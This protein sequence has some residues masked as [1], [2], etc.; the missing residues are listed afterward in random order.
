MTRSGGDALTGA[1]L[2][3]ADPALP[4]QAATKAYVDAQSAASLPKAG[5]ILSGPLTLSGDPTT[6]MQAVT[7]QY[8]DTRIFRSGDTLTGALILSSDPVISLQA[9][10]K[11]YV[12]TQFGMT[13]PKTGGSI[14]G[15]LLLNAD[16]TATNQAATKHY[17]DAQLTGVLPLSG[18]SLTGPLTL[19]SAP[20]AAA[21]AATKQYV[22]GQMSTALPL[23]GGTLTGALTLAVA[24]ATPMAAATKQYVDAAAIGTGTI[25]VKSAPYNAQLNGVTDDTAAFKAA[26][27]AAQAG[28]VIYVP[29]GV[30]V[31]QNP[32][33]WG[34]SLTKRVKWIVDGTTLVDGTPLASAIPSGTNPV[35][36][37][38]PGV[39]VGNTTL[40]AEASQ[41]GSQATDLA[42]LHSSYI[43]DHAGGSSGS[44]S[45][46]TRTDTLIYNSPNNYIWGGVDRLVW[47]GIQTPTAATP[48]QHVGRYVQT[49]RQTIGTNS[50]GAP[51]PQPQLWAACLEMRDAT[52]KPSSWSNASLTVEMDFI[53]NGLDDANNRQIQSLVVQQHDTSGAPVEV[54]TII[55]VYLAVG[56][57]GHAKT[58]FGVG[59]PFSRAVLDTTYATQLTGA[60]AIRLAAG[61]TIAFESTGS[62]YL[63]YDSPSG[64]LRWNQGALSYVVGKGI[65]VGW[66]YVAAGNATLPSYI[67]GDLVFLAGSGSYTITLPAAN[68]VPAGVGFTF[69]AVGTSVVTIA[70]VGSDTIDNGP[71]VLR[72]NDRYHIVSDNSGSWREIF[73]TNAVSP[74]FTGPPVFPSYTVATLPASP[75]AGAKA[76]VTNGRKPADAAGAGTGVE[77]FYDG[78]HWISVCGGTQVSA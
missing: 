76:F 63:A 74:R 72:Q 41:A 16:P 39:V 28:S 47:T 14:S 19:N 62:N 45:A 37:T 9:A 32:K 75:T 55:G 59:I 22:D 26:Y 34:V 35:S 49:I 3:A 69:S 61:H 78:S 51:L 25:N 20:I 77:V 60:S 15:S 71:I 50:G 27:L 21:Q 4:L 38:L 46:N 11:Q 42:V 68:T 67:A 6:A 24:P 56:S 18:G 30:T 54:G 36:I 58:V 13:L 52:G 8:A 31:L 57:S 2:L 40:G 66:Q 44:V 17:V 53:G 12:D 29:F 23:T 5:G 7:K 73:R 1:L 10:T 43:V 33:N 48:A 70:P 65:T 64:T